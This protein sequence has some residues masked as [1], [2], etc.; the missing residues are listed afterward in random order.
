MPAT[1]PLGATAVKRD[2]L[3]GRV[4]TAMPYR[5]VSDRHAEL[6]L[7]CWPGI[8]CRAPSSWTGWLR[9]GDDAVRKQ[10]IPSLAAGR[11]ELDRWIWRDTVVLAWWGLDP[12][13]SV[14]HFRPVD[15]RP[16]WWYVNFERAP[17][18]TALGIDTFDLLLD[19]TADA[20][21]SRWAWKDEDEY[22]HGRRLGVITDADHRRIG[23]ARERAVALLENRAGPFARDWSGWTVPP[24]WSVPALPP[25]VT[26]APVTP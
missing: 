4:W 13:F 19:L 22:A 24:G 23:R 18:R 9:T 3:R 21:L 26:D 14:H 11:W 5:V 20:D 25:D 16:P 12:D 15:G 17:H 8:E 1:F 2:V 10:A 6:Q 7:A